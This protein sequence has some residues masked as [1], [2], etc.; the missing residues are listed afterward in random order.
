MSVAL[1]RRTWVE[2]QARPGRTLVVPVGSFE[3]HGPHLPLS[4]DSLIAVAV[5][6]DV[7][8]Q[9][10]VD[11]APLLAYGASGEHAGFAGLLSLGVDV[12]A[13]VLTE[14]VRSARDSWAR[15]VFVSGHGG[16]VTSLTRMARLAEHEGDRVAVWLPHGD[17]GDAHAGLSETSVILTIDPSLVGPVAPVSAVDTPDDWEERVVR[18]GLL[19]VFPSGV[20]GSAWGATAE[21]GWSL[22]DAWCAEVVT[23]IDDLENHS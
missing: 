2:H 16:N 18:E 15:V 14:I 4:T 5:C 21:R 20:I 11:V 1:S 8:A 3:Q 13:A 7:A 19:P 17:H 22:R 10:D 12:T 9:R 23:M 6:D